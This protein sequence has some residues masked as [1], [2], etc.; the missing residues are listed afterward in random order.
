MMDM[1]QVTSSNIAAIGYDIASEKLRIEFNSGTTYEYAN[2][3]FDEYTDLLNA[4]SV[5][6]QFNQCVKNNYSFT[7]V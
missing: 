2:V 1:H 7:Q 3:P 5:G 4:D 6:K